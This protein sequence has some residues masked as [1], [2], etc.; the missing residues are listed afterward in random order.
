MTNYERWDA[1]SCEC[2][3]KCREARDSYMKEM[4][5]KQ[6]DF[7]QSVIARMTVGVAESEWTHARPCAPPM[8]EA[9]LH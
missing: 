6:A 2:E 7:C 5:A 3:E 4:W 1:R 8:A 9:A